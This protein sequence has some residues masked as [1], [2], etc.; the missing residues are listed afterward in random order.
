MRKSHYSFKI[1][2]FISLGVIIVLFYVMIFASELWDVVMTFLVLKR[3]C[4]NEKVSV[5]CICSLSLFRTQ[6]HGPRINGSLV[7]LAAIYFFIFAKA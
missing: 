1:N 6:M 7:R 4:W 2:K 5:K 3:Q